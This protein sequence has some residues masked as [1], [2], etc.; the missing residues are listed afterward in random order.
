MIA[1]PPDI[2]TI[3]F[4]EEHG[5]TQGFIPTDTGKV[6]V[7]LAIQ[8]CNGNEPP[9]RP[10][11]QDALA[12]VE[13]SLHHHYTGH[14]VDRLKR[15]LNGTLLPVCLQANLDKVGVTVALA[16][17]FF[18]AIG[19]TDPFQTLL[20]NADRLVSLNVRKSQHCGIHG[21][22]LRTSPRNALITVTPN[23]NPDVLSEAVTQNGTFDSYASSPTQCL[24]RI[25]NLIPA[26]HDGMNQMLLGFSSHSDHRQFATAWVPY[27]PPKDVDAKGIALQLTSLSQEIEKLRQSVKQLPTTIPVDE[28]PIDRLME[29]LRECKENAVENTVIEPLARQQILLYDLLPE[30]RSVEDSPV[31]QAVR[32]SLLNILSFHGVEPYH[33]PDNQ[34]D[35]KSQR[36]VGHEATNNR[37]CDNHIAKRVRVGFRRNGKTLRHEEVVVFRFNEVH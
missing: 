32:E 33:E 6:H 4:D 20:W 34:F 5:V 37:S 14:P 29:L 12:R 24:E 9:S 10:I 1:S 36:C 15:T 13:R 2:E 7:V 18:V 31:V 27:K 8:N 11:F 17:E 16:Q 22:G 30:P 23:C 25:A 35:S 21:L 28:R 26:R 3:T 19:S